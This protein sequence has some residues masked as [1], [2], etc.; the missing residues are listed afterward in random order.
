M[1]E[2]KEKFDPSR[3]SFN[4]GG[5]MLSHDQILQNQKLREVVEEAIDFYDGQSTEYVGNILRAL[6]KDSKK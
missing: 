4:I 5:K 6:L 2:I 3:L 1:T